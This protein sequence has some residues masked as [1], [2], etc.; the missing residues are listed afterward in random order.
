MTAPATDRL[1]RTIFAACRELGLDDAARRDLQERATGKSSLSAMSEH[2]M[3]SV[4]GALKASGFKPG[5][6]GKRHKL[7]PR[8][9]LRLVHV[10]WSK[11]DKAGKVRMRGRKGLNSF[12]RSRFGAA[13][14]SVPLDVDALRDADKIAALIEALK[15]WCEREGIPVARGHR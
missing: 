7:A 8:G 6:G 11:L 12:I 5:R 13:W 1:R 2:E 10:L 15:S 4:I 14:G 3:E 9:D